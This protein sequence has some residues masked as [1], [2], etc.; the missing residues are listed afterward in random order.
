[1]FAIAGLSRSA[2]LRWTLFGPGGPGFRVRQALAQAF[3][4]VDDFGRTLWFP[5]LERHLLA[6]RLPVDDLHQV[7]AVLIRVLRRI[8]LRGEALDERLRHLELLLADLRLR[9][10]VQVGGVPQLFLKT[11][12]A[13]HEALFDNFNRPKALLARQPRAHNPAAPRS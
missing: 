6:F 3:H 7:F 11:N 8:P 1:M 4:Q 10:E 9:G 12:T 2:A 5:R 13:Q